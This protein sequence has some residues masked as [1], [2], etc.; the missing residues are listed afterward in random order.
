VSA[1]T[2]DTTD[3][4]IIPRWRDSTLTAAT[5]EGGSLGAVTPRPLDMRQLH[6]K[7]LE[8]EQH[9]STIT[10]TELL[11]AAVVLNQATLAHDAARYLLGA[12][13][14]VPETVKHLSYSILEQEPPAAQLAF[15]P[16]ITAK[17][18]IR[19]LR[20][21]LQ[22]YSI[23]PIA[24]VDLA[25][26]YA[27]LGQLQRARQSMKVAVSLAPNNRFV[28]RSAARLYVH[29]DDPE[30][31]HTILRRATATPLD[32]W[33]VAAE[34]ATATLAHATPLFVYQARQFLVGASIAPIHLSEMASALATLELRNGDIK[35]AKRLFRAALQDPTENTVAQVNWATQQ[36]GKVPMQQSVLEVPR[37]YEANAWGTFWAGKWQDALDNS[38]LWL[39]DQ[40]FSSRPAV[41][42][43]YI[44]TTLLEDY[45]SAETFLREGLI[46]NPKDSSLLNNL[47][48]ALAKT[49]KLGDA[50]RCFG[51]INT[52]ALN[53]QQRIVWHATK[54]LLLFR[55]G[56]HAQGRELYQE[57]ITTAEHQHLESVGVQASIALATEEVLARTPQA[58][59]ARAAALVMSQR[60]PGPVI[61]ALA[62]RLASLE[63]AP[64]QNP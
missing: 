48:V 35:K 29:L 7:R 6:E 18:Q 42:G 41:H 2:F 53:E 16:A 54:G 21:G 50:Q 20:L 3:R 51:T 30:Q 58:S 33:L 24:W 14:T 9:P 64:Q 57:A 8:W 59:H 63:A 13:T 61:D 15:P 12:N 10:A 34:L 27:T 37:L 26:A 46:A 32:P 1:T 52:A 43:S 17:E 28:L 31:A 47:T 62:R 60:A 49:G 44:A 39:D 56:D 38:R 36:I 11:N 5:Q 45:A 25:R 55:N 4:N 22:R 19:R 23:N 40:P